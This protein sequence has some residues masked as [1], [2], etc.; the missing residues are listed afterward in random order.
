MEDKCANKGDCL[1]MFERYTRGRLKELIQT[2]LHMSPEVRFEKAKMLLNKH[3]GNETR[4]TN[5][6][7]HNVTWPNIKVENVS[8]KTIHHLSEAAAMQCLSSQTLMN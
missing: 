4:L 5:A 2:C 6:Y 7:I 3:F 8:Y 1:Y